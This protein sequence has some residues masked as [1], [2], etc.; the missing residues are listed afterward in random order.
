[1][2]LMALAP[3]TSL[4]AF[5]SVEGILSLFEPRTGR[6]RH[7]LPAGTARPTGA[8][9]HPQGEEFLTGA[10]DGVVRVWNTRTGRLDRS[11]AVAVPEKN[12]RTSLALAI[13]P[14][15]KTLAVLDH[16]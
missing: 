7:R 9:F 12:E 4:G 2:T 1:V 10:E 15:G 8:V 11:W 3:D 16:P 6:L 13:T 5:I 14:D